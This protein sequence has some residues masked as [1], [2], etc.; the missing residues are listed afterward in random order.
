M[1]NLAG[2][3]LLI[4]EPRNVDRARTEGIEVDARRAFG[5]WILAAGYDYL[6]ARDISADLPLVRRAAPPAGCG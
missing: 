5:P 3:G 4:L 2:A 6:R 1:E